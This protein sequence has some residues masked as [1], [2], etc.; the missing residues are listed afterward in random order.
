MQLNADIIN[1]NIRGFNARREELIILINKFKP[2]VLCLQEMKSVKNINLKGYKTIISAQGKA[3][4]LVKEG[5]YYEEIDLNSNLEAVCIKLKL[6]KLISLISIYLP[7][8]ERIVRADLN[9][10]LSNLNG[11]FIITGDFNAKNYLWGAETTNSRGRVIEQFCTENNLFIANNGQHTHVPDILGH[12]FSAIDLTI[13]N[14]ALYVDID[15]SVNDQPLGSDHLPIFISCKLKCEKP[16]KRERYIF[17]KAD[18][19]KF[20]NECDLNLINFNQNSEEILNQI[21]D[22]IKSA[23][24]NN[25][26]KTKCKEIKKIVPWLTQEVKTLL[27]K[28]KHL[29]KKFKVNMSYDN[30]KAY[31]K[32]NAK[33]VFEMKQAKKRAW[34]NCV[35]SINNKTSSREFWRKINSI[36]GKNSSYN[37]KQVIN[38]NNE[39]FDDNKNMSEE[40]AIHFKSVSSDDNY[41]PSFRR[42]K[43]L[44][45]Q[46]DIKSQQMRF[47][48]K[49]N[50]LFEIDEYINAFKTAKSLASGPDGLPYIVFK[51]LNLSNK[52]QILKF[53]NLIWENGKIPSKMKEALIIPLIKDSNKPPT[54]NNFRP[55]SLLNTIAKI[56]EKMVNQRLIW[57]LEHKQFLDKHQS[58]FRK[59]RSTTTNL[60]ILESEI[61]SNLKKK[62]YTGAVLFDIEKAYD[63]LWRYSVLTQL[64]KWGFGGNIFNY[65]KDF[66]ANR[67]FMVSINGVYS[68][69]YDLI[70][71]IPQG[72]SLSASLFLI[73]MENLIKTVKKI[74]SVKYLLYADDIVIFTTSKNIK[75]VKKTLQLAINKLYNQGLLYGFTISTEKTKNIVF[76]NKHKVPELQLHMG[77]H[78]IHQDNVVKFLGMFWD[79]KLNWNRHIRS[80]KDKVK[81]RLNILSVLSKV[82][83]GASRRSLEKIVRAFILPVIDY[84]A[85]VYGSSS[86]SILNILEPCLNIAV[87]KMTGA[88]KSSPCKSL[89]AEAGIPSLNNRRQTLDMISLT[90]M[91][92]LTH[93]PSYLHIN[94]LPRRIISTS[95]L[96]HFN[97]ER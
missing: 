54:T 33:A 76:T 64:Q 31:K 28:R 20:N 83:W 93:L 17:E 61:S 40:I 43:V 60:S 84:G 35:E 47:E 97:T 15:W 57:E 44:Q 13:T 5:F 67:T 69:S 50:E 95:K 87:R 4:I 14:P 90:R 46:V 53:Y 23:A 38:S 79:R 86:S 96:I 75:T 92:A 34:E 80:L 45:E 89:L 19:T 71:G 39:S 49:V 21:I 36:N 42:K 73:G 25:I 94:M 78:N 63:K 74:E 81:K 3:A 91:K 70:N 66:L 22:K 65:I 37:I 56:F 85:T 82:S 32:S 72:S 41:C 26:P 27:N 1:W 55:I 88:F 12:H 51:N 29:Y 77:S 11:N 18:W 52:L 7:P 9:N 24:D 68:E 6:K 59:N 8:T 10:L 16:V 48:S 30:L 2:I 58:G 62:M